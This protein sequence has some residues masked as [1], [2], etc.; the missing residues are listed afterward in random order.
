M[1]SDGGLG[2]GGGAGAVAA[3]QQQRGVGAVFREPS[4]RWLLVSCLGY[5]IAF[6]WMQFLSAW[7]VEHITHSTR[8]VQFTGFCQ[9]GPMAFGPAFGRLADRVDKLTIE[10]VVV[11]IVALVS[12]AMAAAVWFRWPVDL[13]GTEV[14]RGE[15]PDRTLWLVAI[16]VHMVT[17]GMSCPVIQ[18][19]HFPR[20]NHAAARVHPELATSAMACAVACF[21][22]GGVVGNTLGGVVVEI[23][24][25]RGAYGVGSLLWVVS[26][27][28]LFV[29]PG[30]TGA[31][32]AICDASVAIAAAPPTTEEVAGKKQSCGLL[33]AN[34]PYM[35]VL[36]ITVLGN[37]FFW[38]HI[39]FIQVLAG[40]AWLDV[41]PSLAGV[42]ASVTGWGNLAGCMFIAI[43]SP[44]QIGL[45]FAAGMLGASVRH[46][47][48]S[49][50]AALMF[51]SASRSPM[52]SL[53]VPCL[54][55][56]GRCFLVLRPLNLIQSC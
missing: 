39:P 16:Y 28:T 9:M 48:S 54:I 2:G 43:A 24:G 17:V 47:S 51:V 31:D 32:P 50:S 26:L 6:M 25:V 35:G 49:G 10:V 7:T 1:G 42:L 22:I 33:C 12:G 8:L 38:G 44:R 52:T 20:I 21:G 56:P 40:D 19:T 41:R 46:A 4:T 5:M 3:A 23:A 15:G 30:S 29:N 36:G 45:F 18:V 34:R 37:L 14:T 53:A 55:G 11:S 27:A 13:T